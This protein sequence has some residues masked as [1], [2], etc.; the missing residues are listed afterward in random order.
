MAPY[1]N[2]QQQGLIRMLYQVKDVSTNITVV[3]AV[4]LTL[5]EQGLETL[6]TQLLE[7]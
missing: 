4:D 5:L 2:V 3:G 6:L 1:F 7:K